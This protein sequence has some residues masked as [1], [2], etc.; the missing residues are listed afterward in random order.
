MPTQRM[1]KEDYIQELPALGEAPPPKW[2]VPELRTRLLELKEEKGLPLRQSK[3]QTVFRSW[4]VNMN[5]CRKKADL[6]N[7]LK[8][9]FQTPLS[10]N[11]TME[12]LQ[13]VG[14][15]HIYEATAP[16][17]EDPVGFGLHCA[18]SYEELYMHHPD[19]VNW[20]K[21]T[22]AE[23][24]ADYRLMRLAR[25]IEAMDQQLKAEMPKETKA[26]LTGR[27]M[28]Q[29]SKPARSSASISSSSVNEELLMLVRNL[30]EDV[31]ALKEERPRKKVEPADEN[32]SNHSFVVMT[33]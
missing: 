18:L 8:A 15:R 31:A 13:K 4:V 12:Q 20:I 11:E 19:Y 7:F 32:M 6:I 17:A 5:K 26:P 16:Q 9:N 22:A 27:T 33:P 14:I 3:P 28:K 24:Q 23:G 2:S 30:Q 25:W 29:G 21:K 10:G 1:T